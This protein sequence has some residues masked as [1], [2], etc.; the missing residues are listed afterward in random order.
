MWWSGPSSLFSFLFHCGWLRTPEDKHVGIIVDYVSIVPTD[1]M[2]GRE[3]LLQE[4]R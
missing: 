4:I 1:R 3:D 2:K